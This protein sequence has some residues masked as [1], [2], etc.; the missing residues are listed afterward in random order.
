MSSMPHNTFLK[1]AHQ[2]EKGKK[3]LFVKHLKI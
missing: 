3:P 1:K 2:V